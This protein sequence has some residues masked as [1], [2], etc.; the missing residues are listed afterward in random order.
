MEFGMQKS[1]LGVALAGTLAWCSPAQAASVLNLITYGAPATGAV[2]AI[3]DLDLEYLK[4]DLNSNG[5]LDV[6]DVIAGYMNFGSIS[7]PVNIGLGTISGGGNDQLTAYFQVKIQDKVALGGGLF[8]FTFGADSALTTLGGQPLPSGAMVVIYTA[9]PGVGVGSATASNIGNST[10]IAQADAGVISGKRF[11]TLGFSNPAAASHMV[12]STLTSLNGEGWT[13]SGIETFVFNGVNSGTALGSV[14]IGVSRLNDIEALANNVVLVPQP[15]D[16][17]TAAL[18]GGTTSQK[19]QF[20]GSSTLLGTFNTTG[21]FAADSQSNFTF[22]AAVPVPMAVWMGLPLLVGMG[23][24][25]ALRRRPA[26][27]A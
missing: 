8:Q 11:I 7:K 21:Q 20:I 16:S 26:K 23:G 13:G 10:T 2:N 19:V 27:L 6:G 5:K 18:L 3:H 15:L 1:L 24:V 9:G 12:G 14:E 25:A 22:A 17:A 4:T